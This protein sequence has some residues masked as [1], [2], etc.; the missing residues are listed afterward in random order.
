MAGTKK[1]LSNGTQANSASLTDCF[2]GTQAFATGDFTTAL[3]KLTPLA[4]EGNV[5]AQFL[6]GKCI[7]LA[8]VLRRIIRKR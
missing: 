2:D 5:K 7:V 4:K 8:W 6:W 3:A 1:P